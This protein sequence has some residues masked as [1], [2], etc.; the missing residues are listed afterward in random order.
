MKTHILCG[1][2]SATTCLTSPALAQSV[3]D[4]VPPQRQNLDSNFVDRAT[5]GFYYPYPALTIGPAG[6]GG[7]SVTSRS[8]YNG[9]WDD[10]GGAPGGAGTNWGLVLFANGN[11]STYTVGLGQTGDAF[12][13]ANGTF[14]SNA[15]TGATLSRSG[16][17]PNYTYTYVT[18][19]G[20]R[21]LFDNLAM[22]TFEQSYTGAVR[23]ARASKIYYP[24]G[25]V[26]TLTWSSAIFC[27]GTEPGCSNGTEQ[28]RVRLQSVS[29]SLG[30]QLQYDYALDGSGGIRDTGFAQAARWN[31]LTA[32]QAVNTR[33]DACAPA[34]GNCAVVNQPD[35][36]IGFA[37]SASGTQVTDPEGRVYISTSNGSQLSIQTPGQAGANIVYTSSGGQ[38]TNVSRDGLNYKYEQSVSGTV[39]TIKVT[40]PLQHVSST[41]ADTAQYQLLTS[42]DA[43]GYTTTNSWDPATHLLTK[44][45]LPSGVAIE[46]Q[47]DG[48]GNVKSTTVRARNGTDTLATSAAYPATCSNALT[49][50]KPT[51][52][53]D[54]NGRTTSYA[55]DPTHGGVAKV[56]RPTVNGIAPVTTYTYG[57]PNG[58]PVWLLSTVSACQTQASCAGTADEVRTWYSNFDDNLNVTG[59]HSGAGDRSLE[60][61]TTASYDAAGN[62]L[63]STD[64]NGNATRTVYNKDREVVG[65]IGADPDGL[66]AGNWAKAQRVTRDAHGWV[67]RVEE[68]TA[69]GQS[70]SDWASFSS[71]REIDYQYDSAGRKIRQTLRSGSTNYAETQFSYDGDG[72]LDCAAV[73]MNP[74]QFGQATWAC[75]LGPS[76]SFGPDRISRYEYDAAD[77]L[78]RAWSGYRSSQARPE[79]ATYTPSGQVETRRDGRNNRTGYV[80]DG[81]DRLFQIFY[82]DKTSIGTSSSNDYEQF[83]YDG[84]GNLTF[85]YLRATGDGISYQY[86]ALNRL[87]AKG[88]SSGDTPILARTYSY[89]LLGRLKQARFNTGGQSVSFGYDALG[90]TLSESSGLGT[91]S[92]QYDAGGRRIR[93][94]WADGN[95]VTYQYDHA[96]QVTAVLENGSTQ[97]ASLSYDDDG[98]RTGLCFAGRQ[99]MCSAYGYDPV[100]QL[101]QLNISSNVSAGTSIQLRDRQGS[102]TGANPAGQIGWRSNSNDAFSY[103]QGT[104]STSYQVN[105][106]NQYTQAGSNALGHDAHGNLTSVGSTTYGYDGENLLSRTSAGN[107]TL[108]YD[109]LNRLSAVMP[110]GSGGTNFQYDGDDN[111]AVYVSGAIARRYVYLPGGEPIVWYEGA[112]LGDRRYLQADERGSVVRVADGNNA[113]LATNRYDEFGVNASGNLGRFQYTGQAWIGNVGLYYYHARFYAPALGRFMQTDPIGYRDGMNWYNY[114]HGD[115]VNSVDPSGLTYDDSGWTVT[116]SKGAGGAGLPGLSISGGSRPVWREPIDGRDDNPSTKPSRNNK[117]S[118]PC[119]KLNFSLS[120]GAGV[121]L[122]YGAGFDMGFNYNAGSGEISFFRSFRAGTGIGLLAGGGLTAGSSSP[123]SGFSSSRNVTVGLGEVG[124]G[125]SFPTSDGSSPSINMGASGGPQAGA[126]YSNTQNYT[127][128]SHIATTVSICGRGS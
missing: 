127:A 111:L 84:N 17:S 117:P 102:G 64:A 24:T 115:P 37:S 14:T 56:T 60:A 45:T 3:T 81:F 30:Y 113:T 106:L 77:E 86:D 75:D 57:Q 110:N 23:T 90:R 10:N 12:R 69:P 50:N 28:T 61:V 39:R 52:I 59:V 70:D 54:A 96:D 33:K 18:A 38:V 80:Y 107:T 76:G 91:T 48:R 16:S 95:Y 58:Q 35:R 74:A 46:Y 15:G 92:S 104:G 66:G 108:S 6:R 125:G 20:T 25:E 82:P 100:S 78:T 99:D 40:D 103:G 22:S 65:T 126:E 121:F 120:F 97:L 2:L 44:T 109:P 8:S 119:K 29:S 114:A 43:R 87:I 128:T 7:L 112:G 105:G 42:T 4:A 79:D 49:C 36:R 47:Y 122:G 68:G 85:R 55:Y 27:T 71:H 116:G 13:L 73:R 21:I 19:D 123:S 88:G 9:N 98:R 63:T 94:A 11:T 51:S 34:A 1:V 53:T 41:T 32:I 101:N 89:D 124:G 93:L 72:R 67:T 31:T 62:V 118:D 5:G 83:Q 26:I